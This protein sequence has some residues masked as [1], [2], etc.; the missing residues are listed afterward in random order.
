MA[1]YSNFD[2]VMETRDHFKNGASSKSLTSRTNFRITQTFSKLGKM[3]IITIIAMFVA[4]TI[5]AQTEPNTRQIEQQ[6]QKTIRHA[7]L[8]AQQKTKRAEFNARQAEQQKQ[9]TL[10]MAELKVQQKVKRA[11][12]NAR[13]AEQQEQKTIRMAE[14][15]VQQKI[16]R[17]ELDARRAEQQKQKTIRQAELKARQVERQALT[18]G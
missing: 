15:K 3:A 17:A 9:K 6:K 2:R 10:R 5:N 18:A 7:E 8:K 13:Q 14:L 11:E 12:F 4:G 1:Q 16:Q